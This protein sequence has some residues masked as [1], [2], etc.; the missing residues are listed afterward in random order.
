[1]SRK[2]DLTDNKFGRYKVIKEANSD[3][4]GQA[5]W[6]C[7]CNCGNTRIVRGSDLR[8]GKTKSCG[9]LHKKIVEKNNTTHGLSKHSKYNIWNNMLQR[10]NNPRN[11]QYHYYGG[12][13]IRVCERWLKIENFIEDLGPRPKGFTI[14]RKNNEKGYYQENCI[15][16]TPAIQAKNR[17]MPKTNKTGIAG[18]NWNKYTKKYQAR[19]MAEG[20]AYHLG[21]FATIKQATIAR[22][23][24]EQKY[25]G[26]NE[27][28]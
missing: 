6:V 13:G 3:K 8:N 15:W 23:Q 22:K 16:A 14:E 19:I 4:K 18:V 1:M 27:N 5:F 21:Y 9:C 20:K 28:I 24:A 25:W 17:R 12:R 10:C 7:Q 26:K 11:P 2:I